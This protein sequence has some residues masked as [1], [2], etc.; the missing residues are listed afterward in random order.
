MRVLV[1]GGSAS[2]KS[3]FAES[4]ACSLPAPRVYLATMQPYGADGTARIERHRA[5]RR[6]KGF[7]TVERFGRYEEVRLGEEVGTDVSGGTVLLECLGNVA[8]NVQFGAQGVCGGDVATASSSQVADACV[9]AFE[10]LCRQCANVVVVT[11]EVGSDGVPYASETAC[12]VRALGAASCR[13]AK[14]CDAVYA[15]VAGHPVP[16]VEPREA[17]PWAR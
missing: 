5:M 11:N 3:S 15:V 4:V 16:L 17:L 6:G 14:E 10:A 9:A 8:A 12:Y 1:T 2:G 7:L 13:I